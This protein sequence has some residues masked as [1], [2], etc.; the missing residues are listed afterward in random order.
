M[1]FS[2]V[3]FFAYFLP[4]FLILARLVAWGGVVGQRIPMAF[5]LLL[6][7]T[8]LVF[9]GFENFFW[10]LIFAASMLPTYGFG[11]LLSRAER[12]AARRALL[13]AGITVCL[14]TLAVFKY[15]DWL[16]VLLPRLV[17]VRVWVAGYFGAGGIIELPPGI[18]FYTFEAISFLIDTYRRR[19]PF[20]RRF[21]DYANFICLFPRFI[22]GPI[23][24]YTDVDD[25]IQRWPGMQLNRGLLLFG[26][27]FTLKISFADHF[28]KFVPYAF[29]VPKPDFL[30]ALTGSTAYAFQLYFDFWGYSIMAMGLG[31]CVGFAFPD[32][33]LL[34]YRAT[35]ISDFW[36]R[37]HVTLSSWL[38]DYLYI[39][40]GGNRCG[41]VRRDFN[42]LATMT[43]AGLW[44]GASVLF[45][46]WGL[47]HGVLLVVERI[48]GIDRARAGLGQAVS[49]VYTVIAVFLGWVVFRAESLAQANNIYRGLLGLNGFAGK[50]NPLLITGHAF[51][52]LLA[53]AGLL[54][55]IFGER[56]LM[57]G[58]TG[59]LF[60]RRFGARAVWLIQGA[61]VF[62][63]LLRFGEDGVP[64]LY[65][66]F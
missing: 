31:L 17:P 20:P 41:R 13:T 54:F 48:L 42:L 3:F 16:S 8:T 14:G 7:A 59:G 4:C 12:P 22:A 39:P 35:S 47:Y 45:L 33:F 2:D 34:P 63:L 57:S 55:W 65:F 11:R 49:R 37:W 60:E 58:P 61:F 66:K 1:N 21:L 6:L 24:R 56:R 15:L 38:R 23:V 51:S 32:N 29:A 18:S 52:A 62:S 30:Q 53:G 44:H 19:F 40:L 43:L 5:R 64:F 36:R 46:L 27:G 9:Y 26:L 50:F 25:Q 28:A 10:V